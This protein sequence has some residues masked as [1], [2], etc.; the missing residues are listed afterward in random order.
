MVALRQAGAS[1]LEAE[2]DGAAALLLLAP[3]AP[4]ARLLCHRHLLPL[5]LLVRRLHKAIVRR[6]EIGVRVFA[7]P[8][9]VMTV[10]VLFTALRYRR[11]YWAT[12][13]ARQPDPAHPRD[14]GS[15]WGVALVVAVL[16][17]MVSFQSSV[18]S[19]WF[20]PLWGSDY[21]S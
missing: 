10:F 14:G 4:P 19:M 7:A 5:R 17:L 16:L 6:A 8:L 21:Y 13:H 18:H 15:P 2:L 20:R 1:L 12:V 11:R 9:A 3:A